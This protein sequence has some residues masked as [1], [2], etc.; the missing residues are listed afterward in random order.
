[1]L[2]E[3]HVDP[4]DV[5]GTGRDGRITKEDVQRFLSTR[6]V[7]PAM[8]SSTADTARGSG[9]IPSATTTAGDEIVSMNAVQKKMFQVMTQSLAIPHFLYTQNVDITALSSLRQSFHRG[10]PVRFGLPTD[11]TTS[12]TKLSLL[13]FII[14]AVSQAFLKHPR[15]NAHLETTRDTSDPV[16]TLKASHDFGVAVDTPHG[17]VVPVIKNVQSHS[18]VS[19]SQEIKRLSDLAQAGRLAP[20]DFQG[21]TF[22]IS[23]IGSIGGNTVSPIIVAPM[24]AILGVGRAQ[25]VPVFT[26]DPHGA[27][28]VAKQE[29][30]VLSWS[31]DHRVLDGATVARAAEH[32]K[33]L[34]ANADQWGLYLT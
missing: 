9:S 6:P 17:L 7:A 26:R 15:M 14:K 27:E 20:A 3:F 33:E 34:M 8:I 29:Q 4:R 18:V 24:V 22:T 19:L 5:E 16:L 13:P 23:N 31:A 10:K 2:K 1:M 25:Q 11:N 30:V 28:V 12:I 21:A 32:V